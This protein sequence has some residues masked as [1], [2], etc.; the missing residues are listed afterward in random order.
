MK[1]LERLG[2][3][4]GG[5]KKSF[6]SKTKK[7]LGIDS[8]VFCIFFAHYTGLFKDMGKTK[9]RGKGGCDALAH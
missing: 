6:E 1:G 3:D 4:G 7:N 9:V 5:N 2:W 8:P